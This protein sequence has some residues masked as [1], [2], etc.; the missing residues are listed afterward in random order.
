MSNTREENALHPCR[1]CG[2][3]P[4]YMQAHDLGSPLKQDCGCF[5]AKQLFEIM[6]F[7]P[8]YTAKNIMDFKQDFFKLWNTRNEKHNPFME[9]KDAAK[10]YFSLLNQL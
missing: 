4:K 10:R 9:D 8:H 7:S 5:H 3:K 1:F 2:N 6:M